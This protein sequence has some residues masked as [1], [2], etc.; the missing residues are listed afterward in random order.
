MGYYIKMMPLAVT[1]EQEPHLLPIWFKQRTRWAKGNIY[2]LLK[3]FKYVFD[4][5]AG[6]MRL[7]VLY[8][9]MVYLLMLSS[10]IFSD[11]IF[12]A[13]VLGLVYVSISGFSTVLWGMA[14]LVFVLNML[15]TL[16]VEEN[17]FNFQSAVL[18]LI[19]LFSYSKLW[20]FV[21]LNSIV[22]SIGDTIYKREVKWEKTVRYAETS[23]DAGKIRKGR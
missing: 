5:D 6:K 4:K 20:V 21:V 12:F 3:N 13:G 1:W 15:I 19:M 9:L 2:V 14:I 11:I 10:L 17:E 22:Q 23:N 8:Y 18:I 7:D 16:A